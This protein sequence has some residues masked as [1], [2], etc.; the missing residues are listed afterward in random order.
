[1]KYLGTTSVEMD[2]VTK[3][4]VDDASSKGNTAYGW[5]NHA[6]A[7]YVKSSGVTSITIKNGTGITGGSNTATTTTGTYTIG[8][9]T[10]IQTDIAN[11]A[12]AY[13]WGNHANAGYLKT[14]QDI[15][16]K[17]NV[18]GGTFTG[19]ITLKNDLYYTA[20]N[21][22][23]D[24]AN[25]DI[26]RVN[27]LYT[28]DTADNT[29]EGIHFYRDATHWDTLTANGGNLYFMPNDVLAGTAFSSAKKV[30]LDDDNRLTNARN[31]ADVYAWA[32]AATKPTYNWGEITNSGAENI[33]EG[34]SDVTDN[35]EILTSY[36]S[37]N[38]FADTN[39]K[40]IVYRRDAIKM[41]N[42]IKGKLPSWA[43]KSSLAASDVPTLNQNTTGNAATA[44]ALSALSSNDTASSNDTW[45]KVWISY[46]DGVTGRPALDGTFAFQTSTSLLRTGK[47]IVLGRRRDGVLTYTIDSAADSTTEDG[48]HT[49]R[50]AN[51]SG[52]GTAYI[53]LVYQ[54][55]VTNCNVGIGTSSPSA[56]LDVNGSANISGN[57][58]IANNRQFIFNTSDGGT[59]SMVEVTS[60]NTG[61]F[62]Y[63]LASN[64]LTGVYEAGTMKFRTGTSHTERMCITSGGNVGIGTTN[65]SAKLHVAS[66]DAGIVRLFRT[67]SGGAFIDYYNNNQ[68]SK[69][70]RVGASAEDRFS[71]YVDG[72][73]NVFY[74]DRSGNTV[75]AGNVA[76]YSSA[77]D[78]RLKTITDSSYDALGIL[79]SLSTFKYKWNDQAKS[80]ADIFKDDN[81]EHFGLSAQEIQKVRG[82]LVSK[83]INNEYYVLKKDELVPLL[84]RAIKQLTERV[85]ELENK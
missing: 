53:D 77:S 6:S 47:G 58:T 50:I 68:S 5:G 19:A 52:G 35:T 31:A 26:I 78:M 74:V 81:E 55:L 37:N 49:L 54:K 43:T 40:G 80:I 34:S 8:L 4:Y 61:F 60:G 48:G 21:F 12:T 17:F 57:L 59:L 24:C 44:S 11:G 83:A 65:P 3:K 30:V 67:N 36:A 62:G 70:W 23:L 64:N 79:N 1:M 66:G 38:G 9:T 71:F 51:S 45:R 15:S 41:F 18:S 28:A 75:A 32:K 2:A 7:G 27:S 42:Y 73:T 84:V 56:K 72:A 20:S 76:A 29:S 16:G 25:S 82:Y 69:F 22:G 14:H 63:S 85:E 13:G 46:A 33:A 10:A 39:G